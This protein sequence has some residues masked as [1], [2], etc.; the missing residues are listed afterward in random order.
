MTPFGLAGASATF[1]RYINA[2]LRD[3]L[4]EFASAYMDD[5][6]IWSSGTLE[7]HYQKVKLVL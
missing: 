3:F 2:L 4:D 7:D 5:V 6:L 1:Q